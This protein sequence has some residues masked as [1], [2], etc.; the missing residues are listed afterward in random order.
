[1]AI[2]IAEKVLLGNSLFANCA[3]NT[4]L[5]KTGPPLKVIV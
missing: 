3:K 1:M 4:T 2:P 5:P